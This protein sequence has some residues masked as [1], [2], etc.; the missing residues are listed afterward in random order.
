MTQEEMLK[1]F[2]CKEPVINQYG[3]LPCWSCVKREVGEK[4][5]PIYLEKALEKLRKEYKN[6]IR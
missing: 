5:G 1:A 6:V 4:Y 3:K 2:K